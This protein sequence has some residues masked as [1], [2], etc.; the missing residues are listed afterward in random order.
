MGNY[1]NKGNDGFASL[2]NSMFVDK[3]MLIAEV[4]SVMMTENRFLCVTR[5]R[6]FGKSVAVKMLN[7]YYDKSCDSRDLFRGLAISKDKDFGKHLNRY[8]VLY[9]D[10]TDFVT[11]YGRDIHIVEY[12]KRDICEEL[13]G[14]YE[15]VVMKPSDDLM[16]L[17]V[18]I[19]SHTGEKFVCLID[20][21]DALCREGMERQMDEYVD[22]LRRLFKGS[23]TEYVFACSYMTGI[24]PIKRYNTQSALNNFDEYTML[25]PA[26]LAPYFGFTQKEVEGL[27]MDGNMDGYEMK[28][29]YDGYEL[30]MENAMYNP[31][32]VMRALRRRSYESYW[33]STNTFESLKRYITMNFEGLKDDIV[34]ALNDVP[35][36]VNALRFSNDMHQVECKDDVLTL[37]CHL[38]YLSYNYETKCACIPNY[39]VRQEFEA[40]IADTS[41]KEVTDALEQSEDLMAHLLHGDEEEVAF[42]VEEV[43]EQNTSIL[44]YNDE[45]SLACVLSL[46]FYTARNRYEMIRELPSGKGFADIVLLPHRNVDA[47]AIV[48]ELKWDEKAETAIGQIKRQDYVKPLMHYVGDVLLVGINYD[49]RTKKHSCKIERVKKK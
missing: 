15:G 1:L 29:W 9:L 45:N 20:E 33:T 2:R 16:D 13:I 44:K 26:Q 35:V 36:R 46:A 34:L 41:W 27:C 39:E 10:M 32:A 18:H 24:L 42:C 31:Y 6:R 5:A 12:I 37:L 4:N 43:H 8:P 38:G 30:G 40:A 19:V 28:R 47:P 11:K 7:A 48:L 17:L 23:M 14:L 25:S 3:S 49:R 22:F 21:W